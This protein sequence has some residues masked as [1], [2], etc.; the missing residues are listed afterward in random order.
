MFF[1]KVN[2]LIF[3]LYPEEKIERKE[4]IICLRQHLQFIQWLWFI[5]IFL[6]F[7]EK[8]RDMVGLAALQSRPRTPNF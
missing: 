3:I 8:H 6:L 2:F 1:V 7:D 4:T 5:L